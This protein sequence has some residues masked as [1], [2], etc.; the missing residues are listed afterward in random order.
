VRRFIYT[1]LIYIK[2]LVDRR[3]LFLEC[4]GKRSATTLLF[5][6]WTAG[7][8]DFTN[9][10]RV[11]R[12]GFIRISLAVIAETVTLVLALHVV[13]VQSSSLATWDLTGL[14]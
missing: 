6:D 9:F 13:V 10:P 8:E 3:R 7:A 12:M 14:D 5:V 4:S 2:M 1:T 11:D